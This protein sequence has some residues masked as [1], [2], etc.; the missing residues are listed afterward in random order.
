[1]NTTVLASLATLSLGAGILLV[2]S[3]AFAVSSEATE[4]D[5]T[6]VMG[7]AREYQRGLSVNG[8]AP[9]LRSVVVDGESILAYCIEYW[10]RAADPDHE[11]AVTAWD[12]FTGDNNFKTDPQVRHHVAWILRHSYPTLT[13]DQVAQQ[14]GTV[15]LS[16]TEV[17]T[18]TQAAIWHFTD[19]FV[20]DGQL[21]VADAPD[22]T[23]RMSQHSADNVQAVFDYLTG[24]TNTGLTEEEVRASVTLEDTTDL[25]QDLPETVAAV[26]AH[27]E[28][29]MFGPIMLNS[30]SPEVDLEMRLDGSETQL[31]QITMVDRHGEIINLDQAVTA[32]EIWVHVPAEMETGTVQLAAE[33]VEYGYTGRLIIPEP[34]GQRRFQTIVVVDQATDSA[35]SEIDLA[36]EKPE[37]EEP[38]I[39]KEPEVEEEPE[40]QED[41]QIEEEPQTEDEP[42]TSENPPTVDPLIEVPP[43]EETPVVESPT[44]TPSVPQEEPSVPSE[45][46]EISETQDPGEVLPEEEV[47]PQEVSQAEPAAELAIT[48]AHQ[49]RNLLVGLG[50]LAVGAGL[51]VLNHYRRTRS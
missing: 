4:R 51:V 29:H 12:D 18:A 5:L 47:S 38:E 46:P 48:G 17:I 24:S 6:A 35:S 32:E 10:I 41:P 11:S 25:A 23:A 1:M 2:P 43:V 40:P 21:N 14:A 28:D 3:T 39:E 37:P 22:G 13:I 8:V 33:S 36:W 31:D 20:P 15:S 26:R 9:T 50:T 44:E 42:D 7:P 34:D 45:Q 16:E 19:D 27:A 30:S 49:T